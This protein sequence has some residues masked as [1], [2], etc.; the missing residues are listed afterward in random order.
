MSPRV[1]QV[2]YKSPYKLLLTFANDEIKEFDL[3]PCLNYPVY[4]TL[5]DEALCSRAKVCLGTVIWND[6]T[7]FD[8]DLLYLESTLVRI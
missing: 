2:K 8:P 6:E 3:Q 7:D 5:Q 4:E 1:K